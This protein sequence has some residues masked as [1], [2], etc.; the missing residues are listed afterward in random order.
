MAQT[1]MATLR[2][3]RPR[4]A[5]LVKM[6]KKRIAGFSK[7]NIFRVT[8]QP[9]EIFL[10]PQFFLQI[11]YKPQIDILSKKCVFVNLIT[12]SPNI[13]WKICLPKKKKL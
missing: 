11:P 9:T 1:A 7:K 5:E 4:G 10:H 13:N 6:K 12:S 8:Q 2:P 3:T